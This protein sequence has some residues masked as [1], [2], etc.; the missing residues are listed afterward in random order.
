M[1]LF[2]NGMKLIKGEWH[3]FLEGKK[4]SKRAYH[5][6]FP[7]LRDGGIPGASAS[8][9]KPLHSDALAVHPKQIEEARRDA[10]VRGV[11]VD[12]DRHGRPVFNSRQERNRYLKA[13]SYFDRDG[14]YGDPQFNAT[15]PDPD[16]NMEFVDGDV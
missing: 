16:E 5:K 12:F 14:G 1:S 11:A 6:V 4:V 15:H 13:Y 2:I 9:K 10:E 7:A 8:W 3:Y